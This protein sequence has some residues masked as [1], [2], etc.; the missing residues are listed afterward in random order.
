MAATSSTGSRWV[1]TTPLSEK[2]ATQ[3]NIG[4][5]VLSIVFLLANYWRP[6]G[7]D[8]SIV[9]NLIF[10]G[11]I[12]FGLLDIF[13]FFRKNYSRILQWAL[14]NKIA[15]L[16]LPTLILVLGIG[17]M[18]NTGKEFM[19]ALNE[20]SFLLMPTSPTA[21]GSGRKQ[22]CLAAT[23]SSGSQYSRN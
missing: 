15:F 10:V 3:A 19:P 5:A 2:Q 7:F 23:G 4:V 21:C 16:S 18:K 12:C 6:L 1:F 17:I 9:M 22:T 11:I 13:W 20:G 14:R 8:R